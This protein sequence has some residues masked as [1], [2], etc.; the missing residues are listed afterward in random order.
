M[1]L[2]FFLC[3]FSFDK[4]NQFGG[5]IDEGER[6]YARSRE[7]KA[8]IDWFTSPM[9]VKTMLHYEKWYQSSISA[10]YQTF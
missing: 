3:V 8:I 9:S 6:N 7:R 2:N 4:S 5:K 10:A 1:V